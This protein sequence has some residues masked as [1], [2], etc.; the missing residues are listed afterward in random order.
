MM[1]RKQLA[2]AASMYAVFAAVTAWVLRVGEDF[3]LNAYILYAVIDHR[4]AVLNPF[5]S[6]IS[7]DDYG[8]AFFWIPVALALWFT[9]YRRTSDSMIAAFALSLIL[10][11]ALK[12]LM[13]LPRPFTVLHV[14]TLISTAPDSSYPSGHAL[15]V[16]TGA[17]AAAS[18]PW[19]LS[20]PLAAEAIMVSYGRIY[21]GVHWPLDVV[22][23]WVLGA[24]DVALI[25]AF[26]QLP[27]AVDAVLQA[28]LGGLRRRGGE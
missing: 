14:S 3:P 21:V 7:S 15:I 4:L 1:N 9:R 12:H 19:Y 5:L 13:Y 23:G 18:L 16:S 10:G 20:I 22:M 17:L 27:R 28:V 11:E 24:A 26:P 8:R 6:L 25:N 2:V